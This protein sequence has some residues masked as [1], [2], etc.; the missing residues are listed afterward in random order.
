[1]LMAAEHS[2]NRLSA[3]LQDV[4]PQKRLL[5][6]FSAVEY[7]GQNCF[8]PC[9][10]CTNYPVNTLPELV[11]V[12]YY[13]LTLTYHFFCVCI[14]PSSGSGPRSSHNCLEGAMVLNFFYKVSGG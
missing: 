1:M 8:P 11:I 13:F 5:G 10:I 6:D 2:S 4:I 9:G 7:Y 12:F 14:S 3:L